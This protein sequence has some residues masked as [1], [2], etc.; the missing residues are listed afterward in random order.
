[1]AGHTDSSCQSDF[2][3]AGF[4]ASRPYQRL[5][6]YRKGSRPVPRDGQGRQRRRGACR[7]LRCSWESPTGSGKTIMGLAIARWMQQNL[8]YRVGW[9]AMR[10]NLLA[11]AVAE[12][13]PRL[14]R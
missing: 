5:A 8:G 14:R 11:Q 10:R 13:Q 7:F 2:L 1:M 12:N 4:A 9:T 3:P 6:H